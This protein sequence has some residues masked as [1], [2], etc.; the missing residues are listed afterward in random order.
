M[1]CS[2]TVPRVALALL[3]YPGLY[4]FAPSGHGANGRNS[5]F[6][7]RGR[8][9][10]GAAGWRRRCSLALGYIVLAFRGM[11]QTPATP[12]CFLRDRGIAIAPAKQVTQVIQP[13]RRRLRFGTP[14][15][16]SGG[17]IQ[18]RSRS[19]AF[20]D[21]RLTPQRGGIAQP[22]VSEQR[23]RHPVPYPGNQRPNGAA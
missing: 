7:I 3:A 4:C 8:G 21:F 17:V 9:I 16:R 5:P 2:A 1:H 11:A 22:R 13:H 10:I 23:E 20:R 12:P 14:N 18:P 15:Q 6:F 19:P